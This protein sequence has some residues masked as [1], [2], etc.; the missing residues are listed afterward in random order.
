MFLWKLRIFES[1]QN[2]VK[3]YERM[4]LKL[5]KGKWKKNSF[6]PLIMRF[7]LFADNDIRFHFFTSIYL[8][9][10]QVSLKKSTGLQN[11]LPFFL[12]PRK[13]CKVHITYI[14]IS[15]PYCTPWLCDPVNKKANASAEKGEAVCFNKHLLVL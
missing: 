3:C 1:Q 10:T 9:V 2:W 14:S 7:I 4:C 6:Q 5:W 15:H 12:R 11:A 8:T 13:E